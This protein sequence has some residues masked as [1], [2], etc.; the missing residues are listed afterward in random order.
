M[1]EVNPKR[2]AVIING[3]GEE[4][5][6]ENVDRALKVLDKQGYETYVASPQEPATPADHYTGATK[7][8]AL[9]MLG[10]LKGA[11]EGAE[12]LIYTTG[13]GLKVVG[14][15]GGITLEDDTVNMDVLPLLDSLPYEKRTAI[16]DQCFSGSWYKTFSDDPKT[17]FISAGD[18]NQAVCCDKFAPYIWADA[19]E[20]PDINGDG[21]IN[22]QE[23]YARA[24]AETDFEYTS[25]QFLA[26]KGYV[27]EGEPAFGTGVVDVGDKEGLKE[28]L[29][30][31]EPGQYAFVMFSADY[32]KACDEY[33]PKFDEL[34]K[35][36]AGQHLF[37]YVKDESARE[38]FGF[39]GFPTVMIFNHR[40][41]DD[42]RYTV[43]EQEH[44][45]DE[46]S[47]FY[48]KA[49]PSLAVVKG[50][51][52]DIKAH[53]EWFAEKLLTQVG[54]VQTMEEAL[55]NLLESDDPETRMRAVIMYSTSLLKADPDSRRE[56]LSRIWSFFTDP[57]PKVRI[58]AIYS[59]Q[60]VFPKLDEE[61]CLE[62]ARAILDALDGLETQ[63][64]IA[65]VETLGILVEKLPEK[66]AID[67][68]EELI[69]RTE[70]EKD[71]QLMF[72]P[73]MAYMRYTGKEK[74]RI[75]SVEENY[76]DEISFE[77]VPR[78]R[79]L[80]EDSWDVKTA[81][82]VPWLLM[83]RIGFQPKVAYA[84]STE[85]H[86]LDMSV[87]LL[88]RHK[89]FTVRA[90]AGYNFNLTGDDDANV[91]IDQG[92]IFQYE[93]DLVFPV[94]ESV[95]LGGTISGQHEMLNPEDFVLGAGIK[96]VYNISVPPWKTMRI[97]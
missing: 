64:K 32:C 47:K 3:D 84:G 42:G 87:D 29:E 53:T 48:S 21:T 35:E 66:E 46:L 37:L 45:L 77:A 39:L 70:G 55:L 83:D 52:L 25:P 76:P 17:L 38:E 19:G 16:V 73:T 10:E 92:P 79:F 43:Q 94:N 12:L 15:T 85:G 34:A 2:V 69:A 6:L 80:G 36:A 13:H 62:S 88:L 41:A 9:G 96:F 40:W 20:I 50:E 28:R 11:T 22:W 59:L 68:L 54:K 33:R 44:L 24:I 4:R 8:E 61:D 93:I 82:A 18:T 1:S 60:L 95:G 74:V 49:P 97:R 90:G 72:G 71:L 86:L 75:V 31:L 51:L 67:I 65:A 63:A 23:R 30:G 81:V 58:A 78:Y 89:I 56:G 26:T 5:H 91:T 7:E 27:Q 14:E 57:D